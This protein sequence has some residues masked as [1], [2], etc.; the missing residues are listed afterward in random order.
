M[1]LFEVAI[2][3]VPTKKETE[4]GSEER[5]ILFPTPLIAKDRETAMILAA[6]KLKES[7]PQSRMKV[8]VRPFV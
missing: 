1:P 5:I 2:L 3:E 4:D 7:V 8:L 6:T